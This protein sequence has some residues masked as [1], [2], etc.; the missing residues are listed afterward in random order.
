M[1]LW[2]SIAIF[3]PLF[4]LV[5]YQNLGDKVD[6][7]FTTP[8]FLLV[9]LVQVCTMLFID[10]IIAEHIFS[11]TLSHHLLKPY[12][13]IKSII[14]RYC[15]APIVKLILSSPFLLAVAF[16]LIQNRYIENL[17]FLTIL[18]FLLSLIGGFFLSLSFVFIVGLSTFWT[19]KTW[20]LI[21]LNR[22]IIFAF[23]GISMP[24][25]V[26]PDWAQKI[27]NI[28]PF[29]YMLSFQIELLLDPKVITS[30]STLVFILY[31]ISLWT[32]VAL[33]FKKGLKK[34]EAYGN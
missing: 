19:H 13:Y 30:K 2:T 24:L 14:A 34:Y 4:G 11:G 12:S 28:L 27:V 21:D 32:I 8:Y 25:F 22:A 33:M 23:S 26:F 16:V 6:Q 15:T 20:F 17:N 9:G 3:P 29:R 31:L 18:L 5:V 10:G 1:I 7:S